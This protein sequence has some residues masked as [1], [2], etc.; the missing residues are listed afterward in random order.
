MLR[1]ALSGCV[2]FRLSQGRDLSEEWR[3]E[4]SRSLRAKERDVR[5]GIDI[6]GTKTA[7]ALGD[8]SGQVL[9]DARFATA[10]SGDA[11]RDL[12]RIAEAARALLAARGITGREL[13]IVGVS[14]PGGVDARGG[15]VRNPPNMPGWD[16]A[17]VRDALASA[18]GARVALENDANAAALA[19]WRFGAARGASHAV[20][21][22][23]STGVGGGLILGGRLH[24]GDE[25]LGGEVGHMP[26]VWQ[27]E[28]C[29]CGLRGCVE[30]YI[31]G[32]AWAK[33]LA[34]E[35]PASSEVARLAAEQGV[36]PHPEHVVA[37]AL[38]GDGFAL[39]EFGR[40]NQVLAQ[41]L[42]SLAAA[43]APEIFVLGTIV[44]AAGELCLGP[45]RELVRANTWRR[46]RP[47][48]IEPAALGD[49]LPLLA[50]LGVA[51]EALRDTET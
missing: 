28:P 23:M 45:V 20:Y 24:R 33:R 35:T 39:A 2:P 21:L 47:I 32:A 1:A 29:A 6:G 14:L 19:E 43:L 15:F 42:C 25:N 34:R 3:R 18:L 30:A 12:A 8:A 17:P 10:P 40:F 36:S 26:V 27:G 46:P 51:A 16:G 41:T 4:R 50:G 7:L 48:A 5:L 44:V 49:R 22:T 9:A 31:G 37:A 11:L 38:R 13:E